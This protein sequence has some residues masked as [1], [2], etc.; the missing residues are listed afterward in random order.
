MWLDT[1]CLG[2]RVMIYGLPHSLTTP[3]LFS[4]HCMRYNLYTTFSTQES[5]SCI[6]PSDNLL[7]SQYILTNSTS[8]HPENT[9][10]EHSE[11]AYVSRSHHCSIGLEAARLNALKSAPGQRRLQTRNIAD[12]GKC[13]GEAYFQLKAI[14]YRICFSTCVFCMQSYDLS[15]LAGCCQ[16]P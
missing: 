9:G 3:L 16:A 8:I 7:L 4:K 1:A 14:V 11:A 12:L 6:C 15:L 13:L 5:T 10:K 2:T